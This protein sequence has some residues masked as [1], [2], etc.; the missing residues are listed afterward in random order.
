MA[1][2]AWERKKIKIEDSGASIERPKHHQPVPNQYKGDR[3]T[4]RRIQR[5]WFGGRGKEGLYLVSCHDFFWEYTLL[6]WYFTQKK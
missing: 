2:M 1:E 6:E 3:P 4:V 5:V